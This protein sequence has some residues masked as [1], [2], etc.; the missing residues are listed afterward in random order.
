MSR[1]SDI[2]VRAKERAKQILTSQASG[3]RTLARDCYSPRTEA[4]QIATAEQTAVR[5]GQLLAAAEKVFAECD[6]LEAIKA[7]AES[8]DGSQIAGLDAISTIKAA[9]RRG[10]PYAR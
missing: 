2:D 10:N 5:L 4:E 1:M 3:Q 8:E 9:M 7:K 6:L